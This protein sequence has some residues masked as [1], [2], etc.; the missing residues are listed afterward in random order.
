MCNTFD[1]MVMTT[2]DV[3][4]RW[5]GVM[6]TPFTLTREGYEEHFGVN[7]LGHLLLQLHLLPALAKA[8]SEAGEVV[9][10]NNNDSG[11]PSVPA[12][13]SCS[14]RII[15]LGSIVHHCCHELDF[16]WLD[17]KSDER[18]SKES[19]GKA[20]HGSGG[21][22]CAGGKMEAARY[23]AHAAYA[24]SKLAVA[25]VSAELA[26]RLEAAGAP[27]EVATVHPG[28]VDTHLYRHV[29]C[30]LLTVQKVLAP[31]L[32]L[33]PHGGARCII[34]A[35]VVD[36]NRDEGGRFQNGTYYHLMEPAP[37]SAVAADPTVQQKL[38]HHCIAALG[39]K[40]GLLEQLSPARGANDA[41]AALMLDRVLSQ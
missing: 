8:G 15:N 19:N 32:F 37:T 7:A 25:M 11:S 4:L 6:L 18:N 41:A 10:P 30:L 28:I 38:M 36:R 31:L 3:T 12:G 33:S 2:L 17:R 34:N 35:G 29:N 9:M 23:S 20:G 16:E 27:V 5:I 40:E 22:G 21:G 13:A 26:R 39:G 24:R 14:A 1:L